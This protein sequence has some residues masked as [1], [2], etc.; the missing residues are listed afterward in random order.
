MRIGIA[1]LP[2]HSGKAPKWLFE[3]MRVLAKEITYLIVKVYS[4]E[5]FLN[6]ISDPYWFQAFGC[7]LGFDWHSSGLTTTVCAALKEGLRDISKEIGLFVCGGKGS[8]SQKTPQ[9]ISEIG[10]RRWI[11]VSPEKLIYASRMS[12][13]VDSAALQDGYTLYHHSFFFDREGNWAVIQQGMNLN[14]LWARRYHWLSQDLSDFVCEPHKA[15][16]CDHKTRVLNMVAEE[17]KD[18]RNIVTELANHQPPKVIDEFKKI[19][20]LNLSKNH[21]ISLDDIR[22]ENLKKILEKTYMIRPNRFES[23]LAIKGV[24]PKTIR[25]LALISELIYKKSFSIKDP[26]RFSFCHGG[27]DG[28]PYPV[29]KSQ[30]NLSIQI[31]REIIQEV[32]MG[33]NEKLSCLRRLSYF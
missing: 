4:P 7:V 31:L 29:D 10:M 1:N 12:A 13:K 2:L 33:R 25:A 14:T 30:Y 20:E 8:V 11:K 3:R 23:L 22:R 18:C 26:M 28:I 17:S 32:K 5:Y 24:G 15:V 21:F 9:E 27:K 16:C 6:R 19:K